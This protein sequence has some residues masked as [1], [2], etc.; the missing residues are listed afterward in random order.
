V[1]GHTKFLKKRLYL[2]VSN[3][4]INMTES[5]VSLCDQNY[6]ALFPNDPLLRKIIMEKNVKN[7]LSLHPGKK[8]LHFSSR[9]YW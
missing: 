2:G 8:E 1:V 9:V 5:E 3:G 4:V 7:V 6:M